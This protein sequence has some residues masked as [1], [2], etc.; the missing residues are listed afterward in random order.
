M[1]SNKEIACLNKYGKSG[2]LYDSKTSILWDFLKKKD[3]FFYKEKEFLSHVFVPFPA[4]P[5][6]CPSSQTNRRCQPPR[7]L[8]SAPHKV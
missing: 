1:S 5:Q 4:A 3:I 6:V 8:E 2:K 7:F